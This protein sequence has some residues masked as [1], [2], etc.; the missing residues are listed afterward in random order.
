MKY[1][2]TIIFD[3]DGTIADSYL[4]TF[5]IYNRLA[6]KY[7]LK[8]IPH[9]DIPIL[10]TMKPFELLAYFKIPF[11]I[12]PFL[13]VEGRSLFKSYANDL[14]PIKGI[15]EILQQLS[16]KYQLG[17]LTSNNKENVTSFLKHHKLELFDFIHSEKNLF[18]K[19]KA[20]IHLLE[21]H[22]LK[23]EKTIYVGDEVRDIESCQKIQIPIISVS[24]G[25]NEEGILSKHHPSYLV[26][27]PKEL[28]NIL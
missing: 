3:F 20:L 12:I 19:D 24:W 8:P 22:K 17:I 27:H 11:H 1:Y 5:R 18:G 26:H 28:L 6:K 2:N 13:L 16:K 23:K 14:Q 7:K 9:A 21:K 4:V 10:R 15:P 25:F